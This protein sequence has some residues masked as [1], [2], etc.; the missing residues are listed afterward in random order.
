[1]ISHE[2]AV[3]EIEALEFTPLPREASWSPGSVVE[4]S[5]ESGDGAADYYGEGLALLAEELG[6]PVEG[7]GL[8]WINPKLE[9]WAEAHGVY[10]EWVNAGV[11]AAHE[12]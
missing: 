8:P 1:M 6:K 3:R 4:V 7:A 10:W 11:I 9:A 5:A 12:I 2:N